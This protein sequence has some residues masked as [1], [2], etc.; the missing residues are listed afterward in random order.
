MV[1]GF[2]IFIFAMVGLIFAI[3]GVFVFQTMRTV[4][5]AVTSATQMTAPAP[6]AAIT[7]SAGAADANA[8]CD[9][10]RR[11]CNAYVEA[12]GQPQMTASICGSVEQG[13]RSPMPDAVCG[14]MINGWRQSLAGMQKAIPADCQ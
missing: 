1:M 5:E 13:A 8:T 14:G 10:A 11:C 2:M 4:N 3:S 9:R 7:T 12:I 6:T